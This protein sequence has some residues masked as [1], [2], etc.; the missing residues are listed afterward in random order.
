MGAAL[1]VALAPPAGPAGPAAAADFSKVGVCLLQRCQLELAGCLADPTCAGSLLCL[2][3]C[4][5]KPDE[6]DCQVKCGDQFN[7]AAVQRFNSCA[8][9]NGKCVPKR[10]DGDSVYPVPAPR[11]LVRDFPVDRF[12]GD[13]WI[14]AGQNDLFDTFDCQRHTFTNPGPGKTAGNI[15]WR[16]QDQAQQKLGRKGAFLENEVLQE[17]VQR[18]DKPYLLENHDNEFL[19]YTD[20]WY[21]VDYQIDGDA[22]TDFVLVY[23]R[24]SNDAW[25]GYGGATVYTRAREFPEAIRNRVTKK[26]KPLGYDFRQDF[27]ITNNSCQA[28]PPPLVSEEVLEEETKRAGL[29]IER[30]TK[31]RADAVLSNDVLRALAQYSNQI[32]ESDLRKAAGLAEKGLL[33]ADDFL[34]A[35]QLSSLGQLADRVKGVFGGG[36]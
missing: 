12:V 35:K 18:K 24:G 7:D 21:V 6:A 1:A 26:L 4:Q 34:S 27:V 29:L 32:E 23:Y 3:T 10:E 30:G 5:G 25:D 16:V 17:F 28:Q 36:E 11:D 20:D 15:R 31:L 22:A 19:H 2:Q 33:R 13:W 9:T 8:V 14:T